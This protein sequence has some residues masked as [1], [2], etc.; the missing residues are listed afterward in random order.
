[1]LEKLGIFAEIIIPIPQP[2]VKA[3]S[4]NDLQLFNSL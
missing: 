1:M 3:I 4:N 2:N